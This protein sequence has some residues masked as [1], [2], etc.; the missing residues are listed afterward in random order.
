MVPFLKL[1]LEERSLRGRAG[2]HF[3]PEHV[4]AFWC[5]KGILP[6]NVRWVEVNKYVE[7]LSHVPYLRGSC[8]CYTPKKRLGVAGARKV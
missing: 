3:V 4:V 1:C 7:V 6:D 5:G 2:K 8:Q